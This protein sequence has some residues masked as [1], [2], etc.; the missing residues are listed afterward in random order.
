MRAAKPL[1]QQE[2]ILRTA[3]PRLL[4][5]ACNIFIN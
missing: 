4:M 1:G 5:L 2:F 3:F